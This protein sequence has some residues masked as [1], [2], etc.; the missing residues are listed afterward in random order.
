MYLYLHLYPCVTFCFHSFKLVGQNIVKSTKN[1][2]IRR[3]AV[4]AVDQINVK[5]GDFIGFFLPKNV[6]GGITLDKCNKNISGRTYGNQLVFDGRIRF[7][8]DWAVGEAYT[9]KPDG[10][11]C[12]VISIK[13]FVI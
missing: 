9:F 3:Y 10:I 6:K 4:P 7:P 2:R 12:K 11:V 5:E 1:H 8:S 13:A